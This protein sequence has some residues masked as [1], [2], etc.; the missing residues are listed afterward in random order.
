MLVV[1]K[2][3]EAAATVPAMSEADMPRVVHGLQYEI[4]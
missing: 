3:N 2:M 4:T 1:C